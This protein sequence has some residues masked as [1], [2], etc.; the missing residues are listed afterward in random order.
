MPQLPLLS[1]KHLIKI[2]AKIGYEPVRQRG[3]HMRLSAPGKKSVTVPNYK[4]IDRSL[5]IKIL[6]DAELKPEDFL[7]LL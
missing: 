2:L 1:G 7:A 5:L 6:R 4:Q 3:S